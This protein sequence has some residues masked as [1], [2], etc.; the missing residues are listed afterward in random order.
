MLP[1]G[2]LRRPLW[3]DTSMHT[4]MIFYSISESTEG[5]SVITL[6][7]NVWIYADLSRFKLGPTSI[8]QIKNWIGP[9]FIS[10]AVVTW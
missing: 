2:F 6:M 9:A 10:D 7:K 8:N 5:E 1:S 4:F 3:E